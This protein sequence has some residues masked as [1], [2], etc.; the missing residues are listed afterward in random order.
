VE[1]T[2]I[3]VCVAARRT[4]VARTSFSTS[5]PSGAAHSAGPRQSMVWVMVAASVPA[6][7]S[8]Q[9]VSTRRPGARPWKVSST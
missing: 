6:G 4:V 5:R 1:V 2:S 7:F 9:P 8:V 3:N